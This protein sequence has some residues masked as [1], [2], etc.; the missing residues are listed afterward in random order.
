MS[1]R[2]VYH[3]TYNGDKGQWENKVEGGKRPSSVHETK[4]QAVERVR[5]LAKAQPLGQAKIHKMDG[6]FQTE[7]TYGKDP[8][9]TKG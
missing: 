8:E 7:W 1:K 5:E 6:T 9:S 4:D 2:K 3:T